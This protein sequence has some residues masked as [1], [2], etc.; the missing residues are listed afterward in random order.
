MLVVWLKTDFNSK[1]SDVEGK[2]PSINGLATTSALTAI[3]IKIPNVNGL[4]KKRL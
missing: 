4:I 1:I 2:I 3:E